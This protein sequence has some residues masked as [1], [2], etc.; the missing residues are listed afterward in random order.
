MQFIC[1]DI[2][3]RIVS[4]LFIT[5]TG[6]QLTLHAIPTNLSMKWV[7]SVGTIPHPETVLKYRTPTKLHRTTSSMSKGW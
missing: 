2:S 1:S 4:K 7:D 6:S 3:A 5:L